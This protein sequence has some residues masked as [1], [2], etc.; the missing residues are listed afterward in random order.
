MIEPASPYGT[1][2]TP[3]LAPAS[4]TKV[5]SEPWQVTG[6]YRLRRQ[7]FVQEQRLFEIDDVDQH[8]A[9]ATPIVALSVVAGMADEVIGTVRIF[10]DQPH[11]WYGGR[12]GVCRRYRRRA[13]VGAALIYQAVSTA[14]AWGCRRFLATVQEQNIRYFMQHHF[15]PLKPITLHGAAHFVMIADLK[16]FAPDPAMVRSRNQHRPIEPAHARA[17]I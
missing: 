16:Y 8:D 4:T 14:H 17:L 3:Y 15:R 11:V 13:A 2:V 1:A 9:Y 6:Y 12:L 5:A 10:E 7:I